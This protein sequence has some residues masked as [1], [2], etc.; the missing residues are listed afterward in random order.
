MDLHKAG[1]EDGFRAAYKLKKRGVDRLREAYRQNNGETPTVSHAEANK[2][3]AV[4]GIAMSLHP[5]QQRRR[6]ASG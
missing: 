6:L 3:G 1:A 2:P 4:T 5:C